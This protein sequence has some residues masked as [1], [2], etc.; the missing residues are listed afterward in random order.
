MSW[1]DLPEELDRLSQNLLREPATEL[2]GTFLMGQ[3]GRLRNEWREMGR[4]RAARMPLPLPRNQGLH[5]VGCDL[6]A[7]HLSFNFSR[8]DDAVLPKVAEYQIRI[9]GSLSTET[10][11][12]ELQDHWRLDT[13]LYIASERETQSEPAGKSS[14]EPHPLYHFQR[15]GHAQDEFA[16][17]P[18]FVPGLQCKLAGDDWRAL[19]QYP[20]PRIPVPPFDPV[21]ALDFCIAQSDGVAWRR[22]RQAPEYSSLVENA[23]KRLWQPFFAAL[24]DPKFQRRWL[25]PIVIA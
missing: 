19:L 13:D 17:D 8:G 14:K 16:Q 25:G 2:S 6:E 21:L 11:L 18:G 7:A 3:V 20:G 9:D 23:Q 15:G 10:A 12:I 1:D 24:A 4:M 5:P 22:L